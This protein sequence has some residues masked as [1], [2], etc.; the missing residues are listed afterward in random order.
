MFS[1]LARIV[2]RCALRNGRFARAAIS[3]R[4]E[5]V[6][7]RVKA[8]LSLYR[9]RIV[10][11]VLAIGRNSE[12]PRKCQLG[13][14]IVILGCD[15]LRDLV[16]KCALGLEDVELR[17]GTCLIAALLVFQLALEKVHRFLLNLHQCLIEQDLIEL[18]T[19]RRDDRVYRV[20]QR[21]V[22]LVFVDQRRSTRRNR[23]TAVPDQL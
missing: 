13:N 10:G 19:D 3:R 5:I 2:D 11:S 8:E 1:T 23:R 18:R 7:D 17:N 21:I 12:C 6:L 22:S 14:A 4:A 20:A 16:F 15:Q 9:Q